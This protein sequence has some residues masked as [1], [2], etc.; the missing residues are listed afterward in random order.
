MIGEIKYCRSCGSKNLSPIISLGNQYIT[1]FVEKDN[2]RQF[3][4]P[5]DLIICENCKLVQLK[6]NAPPESMW[7]EQYWYKSGISSTI[8]E[9]LKDI[10]NN[11][12]KIANPKEEEIV[13]DIGCNDGTLLSFY[14]NENLKK[15]GFEPSKNVAKDAREKGFH[16]INNFFNY[17][18]YKKDFGDKKAK[19][20]TAISMFYDLEDPNKFMEDIVSCLDKDGLFII[21]QNY[22]LTMLINNAFDNICHEHR[23]YY[24]LFSLNHLLEKYNLEVFDIVQNGINGGSIRTYIRFKGSDKINEPEGSKERLEGIKK[25]EKEM[26]LDT[27]KPYLEFASRINKIKENLL[28]FIKKEKENGR[29]ICVYGASTRGNV[30]LQYFNLDEN[31]I[32]C[33]ADKN[34]DK[35]DKKTVGSLIPIVSPKELRKIDPDYLLVMVWHFF[36]EIKNQEKEYFEKGGKFIVPL[37]NFKV[38]QK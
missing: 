32:F 37:P 11:S 25:K 13:I 27:L 8:K 2:E 4:C 18:D 16:V 1:N 26:Q 9:D 10:V 24:S 6:H 38:V 29:K 28:N 19:I 36:E 3:K 31:L 15:V 20:I 30:I 12:E 33:V 21:Q 22:L 35:W 34:P 14:K 17:E 23:E 7:N 5:L